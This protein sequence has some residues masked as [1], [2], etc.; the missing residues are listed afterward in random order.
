MANLSVFVGS[1]SEGL[2]FAKGVRESLED[3]RGFPGG[4]NGQRVEV[5]L[6]SE[7]FFKPGTTFIEALTDGLPR[8]D[9]A[10][11]LLTPDDM[12]V[13]REVSSFGPRDNVLFE[14]GLFMGHLG[15]SRTFVLVQ[16]DGREGLSMPSDLAGLVTAS[17]VPRKPGEERSAVGGACDRILRLMREL[18]VSDRKAGRHLAEISDRQET[19]E[20]QVR[21]LRLLARG[22]ITEPEQEKLRGLAGSGPFWVRFHNDMMDE[23]RSLDARRY[24]LPNPGRG[25][26][27]IR[28]ER[29]GRADEFDL[30]QYVYLTESGREYLNLLDELAAK[31]TGKPG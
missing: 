1:S 3:G 9:F 4:T 12:V 24:L 16:D 28:H 19:M 22:I 14:L 6:W 27:D 18:G 20:S 10:V 26:I 5:T 2:R 8:F 30:K 29:D 15:K 17:Y 7:D 31:P 13:K 21:I 25:L 11:L 23:L